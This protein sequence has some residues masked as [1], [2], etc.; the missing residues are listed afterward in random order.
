MHG[1]VGGEVE[2]IAFADVETGKLGCQL[3]LEELGGSVL[4]GHDV[5]DLF[6]DVRDELLA[7]G[8]AGVVPLDRVLDAG[9]AHVRALALLGLLVAAEVVKV[10]VAVAR[11]V[12]LDREPLDDAAVAWQAPQ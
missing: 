5:S 1:V 10:L 7:E 9:D 4:V 2:E 11:G 3:L 8:Q 12:V 6:A